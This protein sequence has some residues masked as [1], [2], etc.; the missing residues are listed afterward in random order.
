MTPQ[1]ELVTIVIGADAGGYAGRYWL[2]MM[3]TTSTRIIPARTQHG[4][5]H[6][7]FPSR[8][9]GGVWSFRVPFGLEP[10]QQVGVT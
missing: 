10:M 3:L 6:G 4:Y 7:I 9:E 8:A 2:M 1:E 5:D